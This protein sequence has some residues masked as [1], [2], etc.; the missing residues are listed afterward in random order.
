MDHMKH[1]LSSFLMLMMAFWSLACWE[2]GYTVPSR[3]N[4][5][6]TASETCPG[7]VPPVSAGACRWHKHITSEFLGNIQPALSLSVS[8]HLFIL[9]KLINSEKNCVQR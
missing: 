1:L 9:L 6:K 2:E 3:N 8:S 5:S 7:C 4:Y